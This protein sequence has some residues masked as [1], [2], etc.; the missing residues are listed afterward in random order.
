MF[1]FFKRSRTVENKEV[2]EEMSNMKPNNIDNLVSKNI[3][4]MTEVVY[5]KEKITESKVSKVIVFVDLC[6]STELKQSKEDLEWLTD[7]VLFI[8]VLT[9]YV[10]KH[11]GIVI[12]RIG[13]EIMATFSDVS[14]SEDFISDILSDIIL[15]KYDFKIGIDFGDVFNLLFETNIEDPYGTIVDR[16]ARITSLIKGSLLL[17]SNS[18]V[19]ELSVKNNYT[20]LDEFSLKGISQKTKIW[21]R[22]LSDK[23][24]NSFYSSILEAS[25]ADIHRNGYKTISRVFESTYFSN[26]DFEKNPHPYLFLRM[27]N[28]PKSIIS[29][30]ELDNL[31]AKDKYNTGK[32][33][34]YIF[35]SGGYYSHYQLTGF[36]CNSEKPIMLIM[37]LTQ[38][39]NSPLIF[40]LLPYFYLEQIEKLNSGDFISFSGVLTKYDLGYSF[41]YVEI[42]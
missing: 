9:N 33:L 15:K 11:N 40:L 1:S 41:D 7:V 28:I 31:I 25:N 12:K 35:Q 14:S 23:I 22:E 38:Q 20:Y 18:Y 39:K 13:D 10:Q 17:A 21:Y 16:C 2:K 26:Y 36:S 27:L 42:L 5:I 30:E 34:G 4:L 37:T 32:Y 29:I 6:N 19:N 3:S 8:N 24:P